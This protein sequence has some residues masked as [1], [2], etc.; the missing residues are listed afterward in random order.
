M[1]GA[2]LLLWR[3]AQQRHTNSTNSQAIG[4]LH[5]QGQKREVFVEF[6]YAEDSLEEGVV[7]E[8]RGTGMRHALETFIPRD[9][10]L[11]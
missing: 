5:R 2:K 8:D 9:M 3:A 10:K 1:R 11:Q 4:R 7:A 6:L